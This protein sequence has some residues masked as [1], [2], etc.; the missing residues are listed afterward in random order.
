MAFEAGVVGKNLTEW[1]YGIASTKF[2]WNLSGTYQQVL[3]AYISTNADGSDEKEFLLEYFDS[4]ENM[5]NAIF[6]KGYQWPFDV[7]KIAN[8]GSSVVDVAVY[9]QMQKGRRVFLDFRRNPTEL[10]DDFSNLPNEGYDYLKNSNALFGLPIDRLVHMN[11]PSIELYKNNGIDLHNEMLEIAVCAQHNNGGLGTNI[12][13]ETNLSN[14]FAV[15]EVCGS[16]GVYRPGGS[17]LNAGQCGSARAA[18][19]AARKYKQSPLSK[20]ELIEKVQD[21]ILVKVAMCE[22]MAD[23]KGVSNVLETRKQIGSLMSS[24]AAHIRTTKGLEKAIKQTKEK[25]D[26]FTQTIKDNY[27]LPLAMQ[28]YDL[29]VCQY[30]YMSA[31]LDYIKNGGTS[32]GSFMI[33]G[34][35]GDSAVPLSDVIQETLYDGD[36]SF[37]W[38]NIRPIPNKDDWFENVWNEF[39]S[40][41]Q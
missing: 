10:K 24:F 32:R 12:N 21:Q 29:L 20:E 17:A 30:V 15:G 38:R 18:Q 34:K 6:L 2:R 35:V 5:L 25:L 37:N 4:D 13:W 19:Y 28:N 27:E 23:N 39:M 7:R 31:M 26:S 14:F 33:D 22:A 9:E 3:P 40:Q 36:C 16:H 41:R 11:K 1:Q 8:N